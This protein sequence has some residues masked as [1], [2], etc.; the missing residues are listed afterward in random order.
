ML[1]RGLNGKKGVFLSM[2]HVNLSISNGADHPLL[3]LNVS[4]IVTFKVNIKT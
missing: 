2:K 4:N 3:F 1:I